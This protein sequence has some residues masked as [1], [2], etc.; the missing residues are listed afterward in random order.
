MYAFIYYNNILL[1]LYTNLFIFIKFSFIN[2]SFVIIIFYCILINFEFLNY[3][4]IIHKLYQSRII[5]FTGNIV[6]WIGNNISYG[7]KN[8]INSLLG[9]LYKYK[10]RRRCRIVWDQLY[11]KMSYP[12][13]HTIIYTRNRSKLR[14]THAIPVTSPIRCGVCW[15]LCNSVHRRDNAK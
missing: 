1:L 8:K 15:M 12:N 9:C 13:I 3:N 2:V 10:L 6:G 14:G 7:Y 5:L 4:N 11:D